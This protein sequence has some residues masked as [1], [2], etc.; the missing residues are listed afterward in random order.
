VTITFPARLV[1][2]RAYAG[3]DEFLRQFYKA[4]PLTIN[5]TLHASS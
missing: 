2:N 5:Y 4:D 1:R 3:E